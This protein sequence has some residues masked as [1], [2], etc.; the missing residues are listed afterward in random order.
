M[1]VKKQF[2]SLRKVY[3]FQEEVPEKFLDETEV[4]M[5]FLN[6]IFDIYQFQHCKA[7]V[8]KCTSKK[9]YATKSFQFSNVKTA[10]LFPPI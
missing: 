3:S 5:Q 6:N 9:T 4:D 10:A 1:A 7:R 8:I 2:P